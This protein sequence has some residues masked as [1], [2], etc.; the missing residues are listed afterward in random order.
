M[1]E[2]GRKYWYALNA[3]SMQG[4]VISKK[5]LE[6]YT[7]YPVIPLK[8]HFPFDEVMMRFISQDI[9]VYNG[10]DYIFSP[11]FSKGISNPLM[12][13]TI[14]L[15]KDNIL[16][17]FNNLAR[18]TGLVSYNTGEMFGEFGKFRWG[19]K[20]V[21]PIMGLKNNDKFGF[22]VA[23]ILLGKPF[24]KK[25]VLFFDEKIKHIQ[26]FKNASRIFPILL[27]DNLD[28][29]ALLFLKQRGIMIG[30]IKELFGEKYAN[31]LN[32]LVTILNNAG[33]SLKENPDKY[34][35]L[36]NELKIYNEGLV[37]NIRGA[38]F[39]FV[40]GHIH[41]AGCKSIDLG[42]EIIGDTGRVDMDV[43][44]IYQ[45][46][47]VI[48]ECK[49]YKSLINEE[50]VNDWLTKSIPALKKWI[51][52]QER[53]RETDVEFEFWS[54]SGFTSD[55]KTQLQEAESSVRKYKITHFGPEELKATAI[56][57]KNKKLKEA[58]NNFF[59]KPTV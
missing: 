39:E 51:S 57:M 3:I 41:Q 18:N 44:A 14:E 13:K 54:T 37:N 45:E 53:L 33:A 8:K 38:L 43:L 42:R 17:D 11:K 30:F 50:T 29:E 32:E 4:G 46:K 55:A 31:T 9:L 24:Y 7:N 5:Y 48:A 56:K 16:S 6:C 36:I 20:G 15:I 26:S 35:E 27:I 52:N 47:V 34:L 58:L 49:A 22:V 28:K 21:C 23:D 12:H 25:D 59:L 40:V 2:F 1:Y 19:Y 10:F